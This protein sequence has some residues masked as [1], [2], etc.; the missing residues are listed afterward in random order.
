MIEKRRSACPMGTFPWPI[1]L[2]GILQ[3]SK[4]LSLPANLRTGSGPVAFKWLLHYQVFFLFWGVFCLVWFGSGFSRQ[5][6]S[7]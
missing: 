5:G 2:L 1:W 3:R 4:T 6:F 7:V